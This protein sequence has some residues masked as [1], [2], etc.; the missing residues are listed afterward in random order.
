MA[1]RLTATFPRLLRRF[2]VPR[3]VTRVFH[4][5]RDR[6]VISAHA[7][8]DFAPR[9][10]WGTGSMIGSFTKIKVDGPFVAGRDVHVGTGCFITAGPGGIT[11][12]NDVLVAPNCSIIS[13]NYRYERL[14]VPI[15]DQGQRS[16]GVVIGSNVWIGA[17][18]VILDGARI[19]DGAVITAGTVVTGEIPPNAVVRGNPGRVVMIRRERAA[20][21][22]W[23]GA[24]TAAMALR[25]GVVAAAATAPIMPPAPEILGAPGTMPPAAPHTTTATTS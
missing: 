11:I 9:A 18:S 5:V 24:A 2:L 1:G 19:G 17:N 10:R 6:A 25:Q 7:E 16:L 12:G 15:R 22:D 4:L 8:V 13:T 20:T 14:D 21:P 3:L 23:R